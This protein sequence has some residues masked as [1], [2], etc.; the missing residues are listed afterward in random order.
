MPTPSFFKFIRLSFLM[1][2]FFQIK[3]MYNTYDSETSTICTLLTYYI[4]KNLK[5]YAH[6]EK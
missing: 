4:Y 2:S 5:K 3:E 6:V 1:I